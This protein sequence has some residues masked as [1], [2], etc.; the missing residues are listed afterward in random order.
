[1]EALKLSITDLSRAVFT[2]SYTSSE[3]T[4]TSAGL[5]T[6]AHGLSTPPTLVQVHLKCTDAGGDDNF[7]QN[8]IVVINNNVSPNNSQ[9]DSGHAVEISGGTNILIRMGAN[10]QAY[11]YMDFTTGNS[12]ALT[13][14][15]W[16]LIVRAWA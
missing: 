13:N 14:S 5:L 6:L 9:D 11:R 12:A 16:A 8:D 4:I 1:M 10:A 3:Q 2:E 7:A 15:K